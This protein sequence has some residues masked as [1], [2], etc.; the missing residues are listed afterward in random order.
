MILEFLLGNI[1]VTIGTTL[2]I[3]SAIKDRN[4]LRGYS[5]WG[6]LLTL[7]ALIVFFFG[8]FK[9]EDY[10]SPFISLF[11]IVYWLLATIFSLKI[12][13]NKRNA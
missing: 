12:W 13:W 4:V 6:S 11:T 9:I 10:I 7:L 3:I 5:F 2:Q 1:I 8:Y